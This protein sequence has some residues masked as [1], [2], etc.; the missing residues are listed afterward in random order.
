M[1]R[2]GI[3]FVLLA[4]TMLAAPAM[5]QNYPFESS[6]LQVNSTTFTGGVYYRTWTLAS[7]NVNPAC[8]AN[9]ATKP[10]TVFYDADALCKTVW[11]GK[12][13]TGYRGVL[14]NIANYSPALYGDIFQGVYDAELGTGT[15]AHTGY[16]AWLS[17]PVNN[18]ALDNWFN[19]GCT[20][21]ASA[22]CLGAAT[23]ALAAPHAGIAN[24]GGMSPI[25]P[26]VPTD[27]DGDGNAYSVGG[28][29]GTFQLRWDGIQSV[30]GTTGDPLGYDLYYSKVAGD[31][32]PVGPV[33]TAYTFLQTVPAPAHE[34]QVPFSAVGMATP[35]DPFCVCWALRLRFPG[36]AEGPKTSVYLSANGGCFGTAQAV[37]LHD[38]KAKLARLPGPKATVEVGWK[39]SN[40]SGV[41]HYNVY[42]SN[43]PTGPW[44]L[45]GTVPA[46]GRPNYNFIDKTGVS[47]GQ[48][49][50]SFYQVGSVDI[51]NREAK[52][53][54]V[55]V[56]K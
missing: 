51:E 4:I 15:P 46:S 42:R 20:G 41:D 32:G 39:V 27:I 14:D 43:L 38:L 9:C 25:P 45:A 6:L 50:H 24:I 2:I 12:G 29:K 34:A 16:Y 26:P 31:C 10:C 3:A 36:N 11:A 23:S 19:A 56:T 17:G 8:D 1:K 48:A 33:E 13:L 28:V 37:S 52:T 44:T 21:T 30:G 35:T 55:R 49:L 53:P 18:G 54:A 7:T 47:I 40:E 22:A 5:A